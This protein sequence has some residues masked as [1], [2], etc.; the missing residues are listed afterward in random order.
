MLELNEVLL[1]PFIACIF[2]WAL[3]GGD[4]P[5]TIDN[6]LPDEIETCFESSITDKGRCSPLVA[7]A[8]PIKRQIVSYDDPFA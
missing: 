6:I 3:N 1:H 5:I 4:G 2:T 8:P 7:S